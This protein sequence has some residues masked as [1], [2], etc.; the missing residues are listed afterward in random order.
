MTTT[1][2]TPKRKPKK[3]QMM[4][5]PEGYTIKVTKLVKLQNLVPTSALCTLPHDIFPYI[6]SGDYNTSLRIITKHTLWIQSYLKES[7]FNG[8]EVL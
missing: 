2:P 1:P 7:F 4:F 8:E 3:T 6:V 5:S